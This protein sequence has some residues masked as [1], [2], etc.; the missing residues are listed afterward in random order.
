MRWSSAWIIAA[1]SITSLGLSSTPA[2]A[3]PSLP[4]GFSDT[5]VMSGLDFPGAAAFAPDGRVFMGDRTGT[6]KI[7]DNLADTTPTVLVDLSTNVYNQYDRGLLGMALDPQFPVRPYLYLLYTYDAA[8]GGTAPRWGVPPKKW[9]NCPDP[10]G[11]NTGGCIASARLSKLT[12]SGN[13]LV[14]GEQVLINDWCI[15]FSTHTIGSLQFGPDGYLYASGGDGA[16]YLAIDYGQ[17]QNVCGDPPSAAGTNLTIPTAQGGA[18]RAQSARRVST[19]AASLSG[20]IIRIDPDT[21]QG[22]PGNPMINNTDP[23]RRRIWAYGLR[24]PLRFTFR[25]GTGEIYAGDVGWQTWEEINRIP[26]GTGGVAENFGWPCYEGAARQPAYDAADLNSCES[27][28]A[29]GAGAVVPPLYTYRHSDP[30]VTGDGCPVGSSSTTGVAFATNPSW[31]APY[32]NALF[33]ADYSR[34]C[35]W[36]MPADA[37]GVPDPTARIAFESGAVGPT[38]LQVGLDGNLY[39]L[40]IEGGTMHRISYA[41]NTPPIADATATPTTGPVPLAVS[42]SAA[43]STDPDGDL[44]LSYAWDLDA[45]GAFDDAAGVTTSRTYTVAGPIDVA[46]RVTDSRGASSV[47]SVRV[48]PGNTPPL[49]TIVTPNPINLWSVGD[50]ISFS[51]TAT[52]AEQGTLGPGALTW[53]LIMQHCP[54]NCHEHQFGVW[55]GTTSGSFPAPD[56]EYPSHLELRLTAT[57]AGGLATTVSRRLDPRTVDLLFTSSPPGLE[58]AVGATASPTPV[59]HRVIVGS[60]VSIGTA[61]PQSAEGIA[62]TFSS[63][64]DGGARTH[65]ITAP[66]VNSTFHATFDS[67]GCGVGS[68]QA[69]YFANRTLTGTPVTVCEAGRPTYDWVWGGPTQVGALTD[70]YSVRW[71]GTESYPAGPHTFWVSASDGVRLVIDGA[72]VIDQWHDQTAPATYSYTTNLTAGHHTVT[73]EYYERRGRAVA[74]LQHGPV[75]NPACTT[76]QFRVEYY[77][78]PTLSGNPTTTACDGTINETWSAAPPNS[79][80]TTDNFSVRYTRTDTFQARAY[81]FT[82]RGDDGIRLWIDGMLILNGWSDHLPTS[83]STSYTMTAGS[84]TV[85]VEHYDRTGSARALFS[86]V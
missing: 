75:P 55:S 68:Y 77:A 40:D 72:L 71:T 79:G 32:R 70:S 13:S 37:N 51:G 53:E 6:I 26:A 1:G 39:Y 61:S 16:G 29:L 80:V 76:N 8:I 86:Y 34:G 50:V 17:T 28:Y 35:I 24:N 43:G 12:L 57:D 41:G 15:Q 66:A 60:A 2:D 65:S 4:P 20:S 46:L 62:Y 84:H 82:I 73:M 14:G 33:F 47:D 45:D 44:P 38:W 49:P 69:Q 27:L 18:L 25:P 7:Y 52:D 42:F 23:N 54:S 56:H 81:T 78:N 64:S 58:V 19:D 85:V 59:T 36:A 63:W 30:V 10:P 21:G 9:D 22:A 5:V 74:R 31:P 67:A 11:I 3:V 48:S 83:F